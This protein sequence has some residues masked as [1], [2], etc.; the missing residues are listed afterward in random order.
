MYT[1]CLYEQTCCHRATTANQTWE[2]LSDEGVVWGITDVSSLVPDGILVIDLNHPSLD[3]NLTN[4]SGTFINGMEIY[5]QV[6]SANV[7]RDSGGVEE[8]HEITNGT[9]NNIAHV[10]VSLI[11]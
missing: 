4:F 6:D 8:I 10:T 3:A 7:A 5:V 2:Q 11:Q 1:I 9:Y